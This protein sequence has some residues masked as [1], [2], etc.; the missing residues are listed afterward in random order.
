MPATL[1]GG[2]AGKKIVGRIGDRV[3]VLLVEAGLVV[4]GVLFLAGV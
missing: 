2:W 4:T 3:F 1:A